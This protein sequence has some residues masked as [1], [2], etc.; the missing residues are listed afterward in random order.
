ARIVQARHL[1]V[2]A[3][4]EL[5]LAT[6]AALVAVAAEPADR[7]TVAHRKVVDTIA[8]FGNRSRDLVPQRHRP[9]HVRKTTGD[10][11]VVGSAHA[12]GGAVDADMGVARWRRC[13]V[14]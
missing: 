4:H 13:G 7:P 8:E 2:L 3:L 5:P 12:T 1:A 9:R 11:T 10:E 14:P 6:R